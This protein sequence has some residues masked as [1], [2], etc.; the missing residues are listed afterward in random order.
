MINRSECT[1]AC[2]TNPGVVHVAACC[3][4]DP[5]PVSSLG[6]QK[7]FGYIHETEIADLRRIGCGF[8]VDL[9]DAG[10]EYTPLYVGPT[11]PS[12]LRAAVEGIDD[13]FMTSENHHPGYVLIPTA[14]FEAIRAALS[15]TALEE[16][17]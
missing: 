11:P 10:A 3:R 7:P 12:S 5:T 17:S 16:K 6:G 1:C 2:H 14:K 15:A 8:V 9:N 13:D 4:P